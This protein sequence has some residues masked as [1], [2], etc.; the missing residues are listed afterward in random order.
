MYIL[1]VYVFIRAN[2]QF[3]RVF[4]KAFAFVQHS[5]FERNVLKR[6]SIYVCVF[7]TKG[8][9]LKANDGYVFCGYKKT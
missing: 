5:F 9:I 2:L 1:F 6:Q 3:T 4:T 7:L 8:L